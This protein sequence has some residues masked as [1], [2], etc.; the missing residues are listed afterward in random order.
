MCRCPGVRDLD[1]ENMSTHTI[2]ELVLQ[3]LQSHLYVQ[4]NFD[5]VE[6]PVT[7]LTQQLKALVDPLLKDD[8][9]LQHGD[10][11]SSAFRTLCFLTGH[12]TPG[13]PMVTP[14]HMDRATV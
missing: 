3:R 7:E 6:E 13:T 14:W 2:R 8:W 12:A 4:F 9:S 11:A 5:V 10:N 1:L